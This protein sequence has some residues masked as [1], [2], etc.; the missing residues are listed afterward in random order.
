MQFNAKLA[1]FAKRRREFKI[2]CLGDLCA[3]A[4]LALEIDVTVGAKSEGPVRTAYNEIVQ[5]KRAK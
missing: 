3:L 2:G 5:K 4:P 1:E